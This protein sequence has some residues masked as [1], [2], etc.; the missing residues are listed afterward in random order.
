M[1]S[2]NGSKLM[3]THQL[4]SIKL[5]EGID[6]VTIKDYMDIVFKDKLNVLVID[7]NPSIDELKTKCNEVI[8]DFSIA[9]GSSSGYATNKYITSIYRHKA[10]IL[11]LS[12]CHNLTAQGITNE[13]IN[14]TLSTCGMINCDK[15]DNHTKSHR[16][17]SLI[18]SIKMKIKE[19]EK[20]LEQRMSGSKKGVNIIE[21]ENQLAIISRHMGFKI[22]KANTTLSELASYIH[23]IKN[24]NQNGNNTRQ[25]ITGKPGRPR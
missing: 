21:F 2:Q 4:D 14:N 13:E 3:G 10:T 24:T 8:H 23:N 16:I 11:A 9:C 12:I 25:H 7:G 18:S 5:K 22:D 6:E 15:L 20:E 19:A 1:V 17:I